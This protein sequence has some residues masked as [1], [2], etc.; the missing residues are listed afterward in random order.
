MVALTS[1]NGVEVCVREEQVERL[2][3]LGYV[4]AE[5]PK[6]APKR[7]TTRRKPAKGE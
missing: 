2:L 7:R 6:P 4:R 1:P 5:Q 3:T